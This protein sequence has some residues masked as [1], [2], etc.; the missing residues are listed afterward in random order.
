M[1]IDIGGQP[2]D[3]TALEARIAVSLFQRSKTA[4]GAATGAELAKL[5]DTTTPTIKVVIHRLRDKSRKAGS[6]DIISSDYHGYVWVGPELAA[7]KEENHV[8]TEHQ[9]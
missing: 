5:V 7:L 6:G 8:E 9:D 2:V 4:L 3:L 1:K